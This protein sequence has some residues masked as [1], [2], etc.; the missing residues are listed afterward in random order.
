MSLTLH[1]LSRSLVLVVFLVRVAEVRLRLVVLGVVLEEHLLRLVRDDALLA[2]GQQLLQLVQFLSVQRV[3]LRE[4][5]L[6]VDDEAALLERLLVE[7][8]AL[9]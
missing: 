2:L 9:A 6:E 5:D 3:G 8:H 1:S 7:R 4:V